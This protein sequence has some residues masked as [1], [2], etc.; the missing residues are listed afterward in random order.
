MKQAVL[1]LIIA[2][3]DLV[4]S[5]VEVPVG[6]VEEVIVLFQLQKILSLEAVLPVDAVFQVPV[7]GVVVGGAKG[8]PKGAVHI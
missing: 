3:S 7:V 8:S 4:V 5:I 1:V 2:H 6:S